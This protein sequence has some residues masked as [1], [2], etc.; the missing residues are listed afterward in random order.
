[1]TARTDVFHVEFEVVLDAKDGFFKCKLQTDFDVTTPLW[2]TAATRT[3]AKEL[4]KDV[5]EAFAEVEVNALATKSF[6]WIATTIACPTTAGTADP[7]VTKL[8]VALTFLGIF[9]DFV[10]LVYFLKFDLITTL[11]IGV[12]LNRSLAKGLLNFIGAGVFANTKDYILITFTHL[13]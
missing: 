12:I 10:G 6:K 8:I 7:G 3:A 5:T 1:V 4:T 13:I 9:K 11:F 2:R